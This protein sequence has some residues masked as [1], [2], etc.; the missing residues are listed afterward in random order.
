MEDVSVRA[1]TIGVGVIVALVTITAVLTYYN[2]AK[3]AVR[4]IG[5]GTDI[6]GLY[7]KSIED[8]LLKNKVSGTDIK[9]I[10]NYFV[11]RQDVNINVTNLSLFTNNYDASGNPIINTTYTY[12]GIQGSSTEAD[13][14]IRYILPNSMYTLD[15]PSVSGGITNINIH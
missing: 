10:L 12:N 5:S 2:T 6:A 4:Q 7:E 15:T 1:I 9:N 3:D 11:G 8:I 14:V 13:K